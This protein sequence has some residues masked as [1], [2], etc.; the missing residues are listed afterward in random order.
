M[1]RPSTER[2]SNRIHP[3]GSEQILSAV[4]LELAAQRALRP[5]GHGARTLLRVFGLVLLLGLLAAGLGAMWYLQAL[6]QQLG[7]G[8]H[9]PGVTSQAP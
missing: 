1:E 6:A 8:R 9:P 3:G 4:E 7:P 5:A 2:A